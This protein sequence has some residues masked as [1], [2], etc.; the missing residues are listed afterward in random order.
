MKKAVLN[1]FVAVF[2]AVC[3]LGGTF[4][5]SALASPITSSANWEDEVLSHSFLSQASIEVKDN[6]VYAT[7][8]TQTEDN[9]FTSTT[10]AMVPDETQTAEA[11][12]TSVMSF[13]RSRAVG[14]ARY[15]SSTTINAVLSCTYSVGSVSWPDGTTVRALKVT[16]GGTSYSIKGSGIVVANQTLWLCCNGYTNGYV[17]ITNAT[18][19]YSISGPS[20]SKSAP[21]S[22][23]YVRPISTDLVAGAI[24][25]IEYTKNGSVQ[26]AIELQ[27]NAYH[28]GF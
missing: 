2:L 24:W 12:Y 18:Q 8:I 10:L 21:S 26:P 4:S 27:W 11:L 17:A 6:V 14:T 3:V 25:K 22:F 19:K 16:A 1:K 5:I 9:E 15:P 13:V 23:K 7:K 28:D 20:N